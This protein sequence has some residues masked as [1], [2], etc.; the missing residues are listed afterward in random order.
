MMLNIFVILVCV[1]PAL[2]ERDL[3]YLDDTSGL[4]RLFDGIGGISGGGATS[5]LLVNY[6]EKQ[7]NEILDYVF[8]PNFGASLHILKVEI[9]GDTQSTDG[10]ESTHMRT[11]DDENYQRGYEWWLMQE[12]KKRNPNIK[13]YGLPWGWPGWVGGD[14][15]DVYA[16]PEQTAMY[17]VK[18]VIGAKTHYNLT[19]DYVGIWNESPYN[20]TYI[21]ALRKMLD[22]HGCSFTR[23]VAADYFHWDN[24]AGDVLA[25]PVL[26]DAIYA[27][28]VHYPEENSSLYA[29]DTGKQLWAS[30]DHAVKSNMRWNRNYVNGYMSGTV[31]WAIISAWYPGLPWIGSGL[32]NA[33]QPWSG[34][35]EIPQ[36]V[37]LA[38]HTAQFTE[39]GWQYLRHG[40]GVGRLAG[41][42]TFVSLV[43]PDGEDFT[44]ILE[45]VQQNYTGPESVVKPQNVTLQLKGTLRNVTRFNV[46]FSQLTDPTG[47]SVLFEQ[48][49]PLK[50]VDGVLNLD[51]QPDQV[52]T[53]TTLNTGHKGS[54]PDAPPPAKPFPLPYTDDFES[55]EDFQEPFMIAQQT[56]TYE[57]VSGQGD[58]GK[59]IRQMT[60]QH[61]V[62]WVWCHAEDLGLSAAVFGNY[63]WSDIYIEADIGIEKDL[64]QSAA[65]EAFLGT[66][67]SVGGCS[68]P[69][70]LGVFFFINPGAGTYQVTT[71]LERNQTLLTGRTNTFS[72][73]KWNNVGL[74]VKGSTVIG[75][76][77]G[78]ELFNVSSIPSAV[79][80]GF[81]GLGTG[82]FGYADYDNLKILPPRDGWDLIKRLNHKKYSSN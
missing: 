41:G 24:I 43:S 5:K 29:V 4:G 57:V 79:Q 22:T 48:R 46:W 31:I 69:D 80:I 14:T 50:V 39:P 47:A 75:T 82:S 15:G 49:P 76:L 38:A 53:F 68:L 2:S 72:G 30:E 17:I 3:Y 1:S 42:G 58:H 16:N 61:P 13:L 26:A 74:L 71:N 19:I 28:G 10:S 59:V 32:L 54:F 64:S 62:K 81:T 51:L 65:K 56:G 36:Y 6:P 44:I 35:Y 67:I 25:D 7:R 18:W 78:Q 40:A 21:K 9:G 20:T 23:I 33:E 34:Y 8:K 63:H 11:P 45:T 77:N 37:W 55:Y 12:A 27:I 52:Y 60:V 70:S 66:R 73:T